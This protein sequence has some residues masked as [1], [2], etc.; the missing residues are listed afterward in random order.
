MENA[1]G[2]FYLR[3]RLLHGEEENMLHDQFRILSYLRRMNSV[4]KASGGYGSTAYRIKV[5]VGVVCGM[6]IAGLPLM[7]K[8]VYEREQNVHRMRDDQYDQKDAARNARLSRGGGSA[9]SS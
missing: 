7:N 8:T 6:V 1:R 4:A 2:L 9:S 3:K 5:L